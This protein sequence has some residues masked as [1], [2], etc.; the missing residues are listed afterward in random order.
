MP[1]YEYKC[2]E[3]GRLSSVFIRS[4]SSEAE[5]K[6][7]HCGSAR[8][9]R[10]LSK[11]AYHKTQQQVLEQYGD[12]YH[13]NDVEYRDPRQIGRWVERKFDEFGMDLPSEAREMIDAAREGDFPAPLNDP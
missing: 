6:C 1:I 11:F 10:A 13:D 8:L 2:G 5:P 7:Q 3:C 4:M 9:E 12:P